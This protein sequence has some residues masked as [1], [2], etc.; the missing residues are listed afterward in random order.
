MSGHIGTSIKCKCGWSGW[1]YEG[2]VTEPCPNCGRRYTAH[3]S[4][5]KL[6]LEIT[7]VKR[8]KQCLIK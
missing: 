8:G 6:G 4:V 1:V 7:Q 2:K 5:K 3:Y